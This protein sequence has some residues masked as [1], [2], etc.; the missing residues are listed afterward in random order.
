MIESAA[1]SAAVRAPDNHGSAK[2]ACGSVPHSSQLVDNLIG[3]RI[4]KIDDRDFNYG[5]KSQKSHADGRTDQRRFTE[6]TVQYSL[7]S[8]LSLQSSRH[9]KHAAHHAD[10]F[11]HQIDAFVF[12]HL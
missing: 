6:R 8:K 12:G 5:S 2:L 7:F 9:A 4:Y 11:T 10:V 3:G 1:Y